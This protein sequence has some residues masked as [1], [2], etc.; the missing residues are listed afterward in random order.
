[1]YSYRWLILWVGGRAEIGC[2]N[3]VQEARNAVQARIR[4]EP[5]SRV[6]LHS[7]SC[8]NG[9]GSETTIVQE[10]AGVHQLRSE[11]GTILAG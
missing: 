7:I 9:S 10:M 2:A 5:T 1:M 3:E 4:R 8:S 6:L 11:D